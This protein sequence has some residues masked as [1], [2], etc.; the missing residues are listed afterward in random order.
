M[1]KRIIKAALIL[2]ITGIIAT[3]GIIEVNSNSY[4]DKNFYYA[5]ADGEKIEMFENDGIYYLFLP[6]YLD[7]KDVRLS[8]NAKKLPDDKI[9]IMESDS[10]ATV[11]INLKNGFLSEVYEDK[12]FTL[13][14]EIRTV[15]EDGREDK[16]LKLASFHG[17]GNYSWNTWDKKSFSIGL[18]KEDSLLGLNAGFGY[19]LLSNASDPTLIRNEIGHSL[20]EAVGR[21]FYVKG[22]FADLY[23]NGE[24]LGNYYLSPT[25][26][27]GADRINITDLEESMDAVYHKSNKNAFSPIEEDRYKA[28]D[29]KD[30]VED[31]TGGYVLEGE[32]VERYEAELDDIKGAVVTENEEYF[33]VKSPSYIS[34]NQ[35]IYLADRFDEAERAILSKDGIDSVSGK[36]LD[37]LVNLESIAKRYLVEEILKNYDGGVSSEYYYKD[38]DLIDGRICAGPGW[39]YDMSLGN[40]L[41]WMDY[42]HE[43][44]EGLTKLKNTST[45]A[46]WYEALYDKEDYKDIVTAVYKES[47]EPCL[48][49]LIDK[50]IDEYYD[51]LKASAAMDAVRW[52]SMYENFGYRTADKNEYEKLKEYIS[53]RKAFLDKEWITE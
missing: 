36:R 20:E 51:R 26:E 44:A 2:I 15:Y 32:F 42:K 50:G 47:C 48:A 27:V 3:I 22:E 19:A 10:V 39:D 18:K 37:E 41:D 13:S 17:R 38:S 23:V 53:V 33:V 12:D 24:Y 9:C 45:D 46:L 5:I 49:E 1:K 11:Y 4:S 43:S 35:A 34:E 8:G 30:Y 14:G 6:S 29:I 7:V 40:Y 28:V 21:E 31:I 16:D 25:I 52:S